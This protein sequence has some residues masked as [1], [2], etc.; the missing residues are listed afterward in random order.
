MSQEK[1]T[2]ANATTGKKTLLSKAFT[3]SQVSAVIDPKYLLALLEA[4][5]LPYFI[6][7]PYGA[8]ARAWLV[9]DI[10]LFVAN[11]FKSKNIDIE[12][13]EDASKL[14]NTVFETALVKSNPYAAQQ[15]ISEERIREIFS[16]VG[17]FGFGG[18]Q[19]GGAFGQSQ[20]GGMGMGMPGM[21]PMINGFGGGFGGQQQ[22]GFN[23][24]KKSTDKDQQKS[25]QQATGFGFQ[26]PMMGGFPGMN[27]MMGGFPGM[28][29]MMGGMPGMNPMMGGFPGM[30]Q[31]GGMGI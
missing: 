29:P 26:N 20:Y 13:S 9:E 10:K 18:Q 31:F 2:T 8:Q 25:Q 21:N 16:N 11:A 28:N 7:S 6:Q 3:E 22:T 1:T 17:G 24:W 5:G 14:I 23:M 19:F 4:N 12:D 27:P 15:I 30:N